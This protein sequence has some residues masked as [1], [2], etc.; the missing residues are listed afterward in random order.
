MA[1]RKP[2][3]R[4][5]GAL[6]V[7]LAL[8]P[9]TALAHQ[10]LV[11][12]EPAAS[13]RL[14]SVPRELRLVFYEPMELAVT[15]VELLGPHG[16]PVAL[17]EARLVP[18]SAN[19]V[20]VPIEASLEAGAYL[21]RWRGA[22]ADGHPVGG[23][24]AFAVAP[25]A[26]GVVAAPAPPLGEAAG[27]ITAPGRPPPP[28][29]HHPAASLPQ[30]SGFG[31]ESPGYVAVRWL[32]F[33]GLLGVIGAVVFRL[34]VLRIVR[35]QRRP[36][37]VE[38]IGGAADRAARLGAGFALLLALAT[39]VRLYAQSYA[40]HGAENALNPEWI[41]AMLTRTVW[42]WGWM[43]QMGAAVVALGGFLLARRRPGAG[44]TLAALGAVA[45]AFTPGL[46]GHA[47]ATPG[48]A[49]LAVLSDAI[50]VLSAG[51]W[52]GSL[53]VLLAAGIPAARRLGKGRRGEGVAAL[54]AAF[55]PTA[56]LFAGTLVATGLFAA[57]LHLGPVQNLWQSEYGR[58]LLL[59]LGV[60]V[61][62]F[63]T[64]AYN[65]L[66]VAPVL[67]SDT[68]TRRLRR[69]AGFELAVGAVV[70][71]VTAVLVATSP[72]PDTGGMHQAAAAS[73][74]ER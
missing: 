40:L 28:A 36:E 5:W 45:L 3:A 73:E 22:G 18:D 64:G 58:T 54:V 60:L 59:K 15:R 70:L 37:G 4:R 72:P 61:L 16:A 1:G 50:H 71:A 21:V 67:G 8:T 19:V 46:S 44:W 32:T 25:D 9:L 7:L 33:L 47:A 11:G 24:F 26:I 13:A 31:A 10:R 56:L 51:G 20:I 53:L 42:G 41:Q 49:A 43:L 30:G 29:E 34:V 52:L 57:W 69:S 12:S 68:G 27:G 63:G 48:R 39:G 62:V 66:R 55:S 17:G 2:S 6:L 38:L 35:R 65:F 23:E 74:V 14:A